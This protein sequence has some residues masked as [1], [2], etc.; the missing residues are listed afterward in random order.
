MAIPLEDVSGGSEALEAIVRID[1]T[2][3][4]VCSTVKL[5]TVFQL[6]RGVAA[7]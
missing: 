5:F 1:R 3:E 6:L 2:C 7:V 4:N